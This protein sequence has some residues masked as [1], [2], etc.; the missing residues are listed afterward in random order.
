MR[1]PRPPEWL[2]AAVMAATVANAA[3]A[4]PRTQPQ[5]SQAQPQA[6]GPPNA[7]QGFSQNRDQPVNIKA[8]ALEVRDKNKIATFSGNVHLV[9][10]DTVLD[11]KV[12]VVF[13]DQEDTG[14]PTVKSSTPGP[15][16]SS[17]IRRM[18]AKGAVVVTQK[19]Q[20]ATG[21]TAIY[22]LKSNTVTLVAPR[23]GNVA[24]TQGPN[25]MTGERLVV[26]LTTSISHLSGGSRGVSGLIIPST[27]Q[28]A[29]TD[30]KGAPDPKGQD[31]KG[32]DPKATPKDAKAAPKDAPKDAPKSRATNPSGLY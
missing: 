15:T 24:V 12:L 18:E 1:K 30:N 16:G 31:A 19:D 7:L 21:D 32:Q 8:D 20:T 3:P 9:Q 10:G 5:P 29:K 25:V 28:G 6:A 22:D 13:Y 11:C 23:G 17:S 27:T 26:D 2:L 14:A 4:Q